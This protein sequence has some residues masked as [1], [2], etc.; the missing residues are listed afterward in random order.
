[1]RNLYAIL[2][3]VL[4]SSIAA[5]GPTGYKA[6]FDPESKELTL[7]IQHDVKDA[8]AHYIDNLEIEIDGKK[9]ITQKF[10]VQTDLSGQVAKYIIPDAKVGM[11]ITVTASCNKIGKK[12]YTFTLDEQFMR[13]TPKTEK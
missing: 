4:V 5:H 3:V 2:L 11:K 10:T 8:K 1:M 12:S 13:I 7:I 9:V 6:E